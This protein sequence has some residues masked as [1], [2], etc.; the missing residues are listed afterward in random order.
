M[1]TKN[2]EYETIELYE[3]FI[4]EYDIKNVNKYKNKVIEFGNWLCEYF[5]IWNPKI[6]LWVDRDKRANTTEELVEIF[7]KERWI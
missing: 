1:R 2:K 6:N 5:D 3:I 4:K 7:K